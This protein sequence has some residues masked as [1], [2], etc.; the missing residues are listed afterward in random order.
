MISYPDGQLRPSVCFTVRKFE[1]PRPMRHERRHSYRT[2]RDG[3][4][5][6]TY[7]GTTFIQSLR[8]KGK[9]SLS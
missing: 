3:F 7:P 5:V 4:F 1:D 9:L 8:D 2:L 6:R